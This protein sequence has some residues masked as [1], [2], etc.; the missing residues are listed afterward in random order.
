M[1]GQG[2][3]TQSVGPYCDTERVSQV[4]VVLS[5]SY[6]CQ[7]S[8]PN[9]S[10]WKIPE[11]EGRTAGRKS[12]LTKLTLC[13]RMEISYVETNFIIIKQHFRIHL[14]LQKSAVFPNIH[15]EPCQRNIWIDEELGFALFIVFHCN[16]NSVPQKSH[17]RTGILLLNFVCPC[18]HIH[19]GMYMYVAR[20][21]CVCMWKTGNN[22]KCYSSSAIFLCFFDTGSLSSL[23]LTE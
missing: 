3:D 22:L 23:M 14:C 6:L 2:R 9:L 8:D 12:I 15:L 7:V 10:L 18:V 13:Y 1:E 4:S 5:H 21:A 19:T 16:I 17:R 11:A 20:H